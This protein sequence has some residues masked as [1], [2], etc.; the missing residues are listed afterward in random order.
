LSTAANSAAWVVHTVPG[1]PTARTPYSW[2]V[3]ENARG[4]VLICLTISK[5]QINAIGSSRFHN[6]K[7]V[8]K[9][10]IL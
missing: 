4:H 5:S 7:D 1:F 8:T 9:L 10:K 2:P 3:A 6:I